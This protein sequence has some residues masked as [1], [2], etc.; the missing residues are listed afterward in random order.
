MSMS[1]EKCSRCGR[2]LPTQLGDLCDECW[3]ILGCW[4]NFRKTGT[5]QATSQDT[6]MICALD[7]RSADVV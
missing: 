3:E 4:G 6:K 7:D 1:G 2:I 5:T